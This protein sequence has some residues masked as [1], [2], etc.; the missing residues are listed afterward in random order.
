MKIVNELGA[1]AHLMW[2]E[3][4]ALLVRAYRYAIGLRRCSLEGL[5][6]YAEAEAERPTEIRTTGEIAESDDCRSSCTTAGND[7]GDDGDDGEEKQKERGEGEIRLGQAAAK[8]RERVEAE[9]LALCAEVVRLVDDVLLPAAS[10]GASVASCLTLRGD[11]FRY[12]AEA[13]ADG[14]GKTE[15]ARAAA[16]DYSRALTAT[17]SFPAAHP[18]RLAATLG[19]ALLCAHA[20]DSPVSAI[21]LGTAA[22]ADAIPALPKLTNDASRA[23]ADALLDSFRQYIDVWM[24]ARTH[25]T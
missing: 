15:A 24:S 14:T 19:F 7:D 22:L 8:Y 20:L 13:S 16:M 4:R 10:S 23:E 9:L 11:L 17:C 18:A 2:R 5:D 12:A 21:N 6:L 1:E 25:K 3:E